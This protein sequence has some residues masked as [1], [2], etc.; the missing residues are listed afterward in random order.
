M[1]ASPSILV[2][3]CAGSQ[4]AKGLAKVEYRSEGV[5]IYKYTLSQ[6]HHWSHH[7][8]TAVP[9]T[10][11]HEIVLLSGWCRAAQPEHTTPK[12]WGRWCGIS[13]IWEKLRIK[14]LLGEAIHTI[15]SIQCYFSHNSN[16]LHIANDHILSWQ[17]IS[18]IKHKHSTAIWR[19]TSQIGGCRFINI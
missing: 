19:D 3:V 15:V 4:S 1:W 9:I 17:C 12:I 7:S 5:V 8:E 14:R 16:V 2:H 11:T 13:T 6:S 18:G 10:V